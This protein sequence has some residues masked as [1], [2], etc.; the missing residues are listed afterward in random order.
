M[1]QVGLFCDGMVGAE[2]WISPFHLR[3]GLLL[4]LLGAVPFTVHAGSGRPLSTVADLLLDGVQAGE[5]FG[6]SMA[7]AGDVNGDG[8]SDL[9]V[10]MP[11]HDNGALVDAGR[12]MVFHGSPTGLSATPA[13]TAAG[14]LASARFGHSVSTAGDVNGDGYSDIIIG[15]PGHAGQGA[16]FVYHGSALGLQ[17]T[18]AWTAL[19]GEAGAGYGTSVALAGDV[20]N[21][22][23]SDVLVGAPLANEGGADRGKVYCYRGSAGTGVV[24]APY[25]TWSGVQDNGQFG[26]S[27]AGAGD[28]NGDGRSDVVVGEPYFGTT[29]PLVRGRVSIFH[30]NGAGLSLNGT[31]EGQLSNNHFG[32]AVSAAGDMNGDGYGELLVGAP[33]VTSG[34]GRVYAYR[35]G[36]SG[37]EAT[38]TSTYTG[39][40]GTNGRVGSAVGLAGDVNGDGYADVVVGAPLHDGTFTDAGQVLLFIG[41]PGT[42]SHFGTPYRTF[43]GTQANAQLGY[44]VHTAGDVDGDGVSELV[45]GMP[46]HGVGGRVAVHLGGPEGLQTSAVW[47]QESDVVDAVMGY[48][49][50][51]AG[52]VNG[53][54]YADI[55][56]GLPGINAA[57][58]YLGS[59]SG[60][61]SSASW[62]ATGSSAGERFGEVV[63]GAGDVNG[64][65]YSDVLIGAPA[66]DSYRGRAYVFLGSSTGLQATYHWR[67]TGSAIQVRY[68]EGV[69]SSGDVNGDGYSDIVIGASLEAGDL[70]TVYA[71]YGGPSGIPA[72]AS[73][74]EVGGQMNSWFGESLASAGD[75]DGDGYDDLLVGAMRYDEGGRMEC[76]AVFL[77]R[78]SP[79]GLEAAPTRTIYGDQAGCE[80][81]VGLAFA[82]DVNGDGYSDIAIGA[83]QYMNS[84][85]S[86]GRA[87]VYHGSVSGYAATEDWM[88]F[89][90]TGG[91]WGMS[92]ASAGDVNGDGYGDLVV[93][94]PYFAQGYLDEGCAVVYLGSA[95]GLGATPSWTAVGGA[96]GRRTG[97]A[98]CGAGDV[99]GD[100]YGDVVVGVPEFTSGQSREGRALVFMGVTDQARKAR[101]R[102]YRTD[103]TTPVQTSN[104]TF[105]SSCGWGVGQEVWSIMGRAQVKLAWEFKGHGPPFQ[106]SP[107]TG[108]TGSTGQDAGWVDTGLSGS[109][110][111]R[112]LAT[113]PGTTSHPAWRVRVRHHPATLLDGRVYGRWFYHGLHDQQVTSVK[114]DLVSCGPLPVELVS[115]QATCTEGDGRLEWVTATERNCARFIIERSAD[116]WT[117][118]QLGEV[119]CIGYSQS[120]QRYEYVDPFPSQSQAYYRIRQVDADGAVHLFPMV[121]LEGCSRS[122]GTIYAWPNPVSDVLNVR[123]G[124]ILGLDGTDQ[125]AEVLDA[126][127]R[128]V[129]KR[130]IVPSGVS[131]SIPMADK[132]PGV[133]ALVIRSSDGTL[134]GTLRVVRE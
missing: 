92:V 109:E 127:G 85:W 69:A 19:G 76:G 77:Y 61:V 73:W 114:S 70:G 86:T 51:H 71:Y 54:G 46:G 66:Y 63:R 29:T 122:S 132:A 4:L 57:R 103:L 107:F 68:G 60:T 100:G 59:S 47:A 124:P 50:A 25:W 111:K 82:G 118:E 115:M 117:W 1:L 6:A 119:D 49:V 2:K 78:G 98:V 62:S 112:T 13:W 15:A 67:G 120:S 90:P 5:R 21:D 91:Y 35:G 80:F 94:S 41:A 37:I 20:N 89:D 123:Y 131:L 108:W 30:G 23:I 39:G 130:T 53:D 31:R 72:T 34:R 11:D 7:T 105:E 33:G 95:T 42:G 38:A 58:L 84:A 74:V 99:D 22:L 40:T 102:Q 48:S 32:Y 104:G 12:V 96:T 125:W 106:G 83:Y 8:Y 97:Y 126:T 16:V 43:T 110:L 133:Y 45:Y 64:D 81:G 28:L 14:T 10:G 116:A 3:V 113:T 36:A 75:A 88:S 101:T 134:H 18:A 44:A 129:E 26:F 93:G 24:T 52:D 56:V 79:T 27:V 55:I 65:G 17:A 87:Y 128:V 121:S 9:I